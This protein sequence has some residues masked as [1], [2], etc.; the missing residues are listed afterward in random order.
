MLSQ[1]AACHV[2]SFLRVPVLLYI[3]GDVL[4]LSLQPSQASLLPAP[5]PARLPCGGTAAEPPVTGF[6]APPCSCQR[7]AIPEANLRRSPRSF[8]QEKKWP[9][10]CHCVLCTAACRIH[11]MMNKLETTVVCFQTPFLLLWMSV[12]EAQEGIKMTGGVGKEV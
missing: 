2:P 4:R 1:G 7:S 3:A 11:V 8:F 10:K 6:P 9:Q 5:Q 12:R